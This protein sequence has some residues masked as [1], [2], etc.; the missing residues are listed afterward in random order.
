MSAFKRLI[1][2]WVKSAS[3]SNTE[4]IKSSLCN[5]CSSFTLV[6]LLGVKNDD[7]VDSIA[8]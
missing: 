8:A 7:K 2:P 1:P 5:Y 3:A 6:S 4:A